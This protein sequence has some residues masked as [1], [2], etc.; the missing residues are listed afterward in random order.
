MLSQINS[1]HLTFTWNDSVFS[2]YQAVYHYKINETNCGKYQNDSTSIGVIS[3]PTSTDINS[4]SC[5]ID[6]NTLA[7]IPDTCAIIIQP[8][9]CGNISGNQSVFLLNGN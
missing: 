4:V 1:S 5:V 3:C 9:V 7:T 2:D 8:V 6:I